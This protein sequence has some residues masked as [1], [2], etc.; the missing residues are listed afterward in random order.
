MP[1]RPRV[2]VTAPGRSSQPLWG[3]DSRRKRGASSA[4]A[5]PIGVLISRVIRQPLMSMPRKL[6]RPVSQ[7][8]SI[9][10]TAAPAPD[11]AAYT[12]NARLRC[13][14]AGNVVAISASA[15]GEARAA[16]RPCRPRAASSRPSL[17]ARPPSSEATPKIDQAD[18]EDPAT[19]VEVTEAAAE[20]QQAAEGQRVAG[21]DPGQV[22]AGDVE[23]GLD[24]GQRDVDDGAVEHHHQLRHGDEH[25]GPSEV[26]L[27]R[28]FAGSDLLGLRVRRS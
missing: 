8:P 13:G 28:L 4:A 16:P 11:M 15:A 17:V 12:A 20:Q 6:S 23:V 19:S 14:P 21:D 3:C 1:S 5:M 10:P 24:V 26:E 22:G 18:H 2:P 27:L 7:P 9:R 25:E